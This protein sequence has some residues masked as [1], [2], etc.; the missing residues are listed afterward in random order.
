ML[1]VWHW[2]LIEREI[3]WIYSLRKSSRRCHSN[4]LL[5]PYHKPLDPM[6]DLYDGQ[7]FDLK[8]TVDIL[9]RMDVIPVE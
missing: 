5:I 2:I 6:M 4:I 3:Y 7:T 1:S 8:I 9:M